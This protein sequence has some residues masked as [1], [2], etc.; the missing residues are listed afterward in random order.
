M[1]EIFIFKTSVHTQAHIQQ[2]AM[3]FGPVESIKQWSF[4][5]EDCD[6][7]LRVVVSPDFEAESITQL[8]GNAG[9]ACEHMAYEL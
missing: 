7:I 2:V 9:V 5:L 8:L 3:L 4:D 1:T 6:R